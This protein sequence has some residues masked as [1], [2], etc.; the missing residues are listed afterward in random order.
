M[1][2][3]RYLISCLLTLEHSLRPIRNPLDLGM[4]LLNYLLHA[5]LR[6]LQIIGQ[7]FAIQ[8]VLPQHLVVLLPRYLYHLVCT[9]RSLYRGIDSCAARLACWR[10]ERDLDC[11]RVGRFGRERCEGM[12]GGGDGGRNGL[13]VLSAVSWDE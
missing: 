13:Y 6:L 7:H 11:E 5:L 3:N 10:W 1:Q 9:L 2:Y 12:R 4:P 8:L